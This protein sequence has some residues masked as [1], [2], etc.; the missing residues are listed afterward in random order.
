MVHSIRAV[1]RARREAL[2]EL[3]ASTH[4]LTIPAAAAYVP[5]SVARLR[6][7]LR[8]HPLDC[9]RCPAYRK[10]GHGPPR[11]VFS[12]RDIGQMR[13]ALLFGRKR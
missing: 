2:R 8:D 12:P 3:A 9:D 5:S 6:R 10:I 1:R 7:W 11:R 13:D 4:Y